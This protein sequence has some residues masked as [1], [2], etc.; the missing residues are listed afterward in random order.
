[1]CWI[2]DHGAALELVVEVTAALD[3][4]DALRATKAVEPFLDDL[5]NW[6][7]RRSRRRFWKSEADADKNAAY[8][9]LYTC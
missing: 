3:D 8:S 1:M 9:T 2:A 4:Y 7:V 5:S 6:Y